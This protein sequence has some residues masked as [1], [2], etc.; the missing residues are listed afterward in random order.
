MPTRYAPSPPE[1]DVHWRL[2]ARCRDADP[3]MFA[4]SGGD[5]PT[6]PR[7]AIEAADRYCRPCPVQAECRAWAAE[8]GHEALGVWGRQWRHA[9]DY[10]WC[11]LTV[12]DIPA[13]PRRPL[14]PVK[15]PTLPPLTETQRAVLEAV[16]EAPTP[17]GAVMATAGVS[18]KRVNRALAALA[19]RGLV[20]SPQWGVWVRIVVDAKAAA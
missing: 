3:E 8:L 20:A 12:V 19:R 13:P 4:P 17:R 16:G 15:P 6:P 7:Y 10:R 9:S 5:L 11:R 2:R 18:Q 1:D 14:D